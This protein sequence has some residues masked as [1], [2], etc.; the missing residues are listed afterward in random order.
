MADHALNDE[1]I[2]LMCDI[3]QNG[4][5]IM[6]TRKQPNSNGLSRRN[7]LCDASIKKSPARAATR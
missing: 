6:T 4:K 7:S 2:A 5:I 1:E 3:A